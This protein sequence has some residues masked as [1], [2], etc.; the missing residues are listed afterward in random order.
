MRKTHRLLCI[1]LL[2]IGLMACG[3]LIARFFSA[4]KETNKL[5][6]TWVEGT[7]LPLVVEG[8]VL[9]NHERPVTGQVVDI[10]TG[11]GGNLVTTDSCGRFSVNVGELE[12]VSVK[13][14]GVDTVEWGLLT[15]PSVQEGIT[16][17]IR[18]K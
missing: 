10:V 3:A 8:V 16:F 2:A 5:V 14:D 4:R 13:V 7:G 1:V 6:L 11:S 12:I 9:D 17:T 15:G 18:I